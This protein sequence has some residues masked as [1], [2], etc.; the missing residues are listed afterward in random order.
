MK[1]QKLA[2]NKLGMDGVQSISLEF[3]GEVSHNYILTQVIEK[4][5]KAGFASEKEIREEW[6]NLLPTKGKEV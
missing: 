2:D 4:L 5:S 6:S 3:N 1:Y